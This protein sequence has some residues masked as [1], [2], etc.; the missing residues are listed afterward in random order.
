MKLSGHFRL[1]GLIPVI[2]FTLFSLVSSQ[3]KAQAP[4]TDQ[5]AVLQKLVDLPSLQP[6]FLKK[7]DGTYDRVNIMQNP[8]VTIAEG[9][10]VQ[11]FGKPVFILQRGDVNQNTRS[12]FLFQEL[13]IGT[14]EASVETDFFFFSG[15]TLNKVKAVVKMK[16][17]NN[18]WEVISSKLEKE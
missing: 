3:V 15:Q 5:A 8:T 13:N 17:N 2:L 6:Y 9:V 4:A 12:Y 18:E 1:S 7:A 14:A 10:A 16:K 11:K